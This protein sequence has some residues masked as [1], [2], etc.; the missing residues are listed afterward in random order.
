MGLV[1]RGLL[2]MSMLRRYQ[3]SGGF[4]Q[5]LKLIETCDPQKKAKFLNMIENEDIRWAKALKDKMLTIERIFTWDDSILAEIVTHLPEKILATLLLKFDDERRGRLEGTLSES[6]KRRVKYALE[7]FKPTTGEMNSVLI[8]FVSKVR[9]LI[10]DGYLIAERFD[11]GLVLGRDIE[12]DLAQGTYQSEPP[13][14]DTA[15]E[16]EKKESQA[17]SLPPLSDNPA[18]LKKMVETLYLENQKL[19]AENKALK[20]KL[21]IN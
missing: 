3:K 12:E 15:K 19:K 9:S 2:Q 21:N 18:T 20:A 11:R 8:T 10:V 7:D 17:E 6:Q 13:P 14:V 16:P 5:L 4:L 1:L